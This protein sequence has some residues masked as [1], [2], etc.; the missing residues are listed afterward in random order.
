MGTD[1]FEFVE[2]CSPEP[3]KLEKDFT[4]MGFER[5]A[6]HKSKKIALF[7]QGEINF[8]L[9]DEPTS[10]ARQFALQHGAAAC[11]MGFRVKDA[12]KA[13]NRAIQMGAKP[14]EGTELLA[15]YGVGGSL[16]YF[17]DKYKTQTIYDI[18]FNF[19]SADKNP[20]G[21]GL[22]YIDHLT[23]N[24]HRGGMDKLA[25]F[26][27]DLFNFREIRYFDI[28]GKMTGLI[29]R[30]MTSPCG[31]IRIPINEATDDKSQ[32]EEFI[33][34]FKGEGIQHIALG[35]TDIYATVTDMRDRGIEF[36]Y[37]PD[38]YFAKLNTRIPW[39]QENVQKLQNLKILMDGGETPQG[40]L[41]LQIFTKNMLGPV[42][43]EII[44]RKGNEGFGEGNF[45]AL[46]EA[47]EQD[48]I[49]RGKL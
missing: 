37:T 28:K 47:I 7:R 13:Y 44:Q 40:G 12:D 36:L 5:V 43:F 2:F 14:F 24:V 31:K 4:A 17:I 15:I 42:F 1:G 20:K 8:I 39:H 25:K 16:I 26:Y 34:E 21:A 9:N 46:F 38:T 10:H 6:E 22:T 30:A 23:H 45:Q 33:D 35:T 29:S 41:L 27:E 49:N 32:I 18:Y 11:G 48:Q 19:I 3:Q